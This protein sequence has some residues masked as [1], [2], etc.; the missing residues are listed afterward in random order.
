MGPTILMQLLHPPTLSRCKVM[1]LAFKMGTH[2]LEYALAYSPAGWT[3]VN[4]AYT[5]HTACRALA[6]VCRSGCSRSETS[7]WHTSKAAPGISCIWMNVVSGQKKKGG[8]ADILPQAQPCQ[9]ISQNSWKSRFHTRWYT[10]RV[11]QH[12]NHVYTE[13][14]A[15]LKYSKNRG[16][17]RNCRDLS[18]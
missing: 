15:G 14:A 18:P 12:L 3:T 4:T 8:E 13:S 16:N 2:G 11:L 10:L 5:C 17:L 7:R 6:G 9:L 1:S